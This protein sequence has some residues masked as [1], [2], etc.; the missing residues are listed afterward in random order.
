M[1]ETSNEIDVEKS[2]LRLNT[3]NVI[4]GETILI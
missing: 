3:T 4:A 2:Y 1:I